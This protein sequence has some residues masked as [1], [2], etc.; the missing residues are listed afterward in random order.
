MVYARLMHKMN[1]SKDSDNRDNNNNKIIII[2]TLIIIITIIVVI[3]AT[4]WHDQSE[5]SISNT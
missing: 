3:V 2:I 1:T 5:S 4:G